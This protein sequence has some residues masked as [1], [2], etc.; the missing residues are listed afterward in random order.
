MDRIEL[1]LECLRHKH[2]DIVEVMRVKTL[3][4]YL[5]QLETYIS[6]YPNRMSENLNS[7]FCQV[8]SNY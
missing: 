1:Y 5:T 4:P 6:C 2:M 8:N 7:L 3:I